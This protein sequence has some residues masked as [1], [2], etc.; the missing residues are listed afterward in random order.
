MSLILITNPPTELVASTDWTDLEAR[1]N[2]NMLGY[3]LSIPTFT[4]TNWDGSTTIPAIAQGSIV[5]VG[6]SF[7]QADVD[8]ALTLE[9]GISDGIVH[10][11][12][13]TTDAGAT[14]TPTLTSD[15]IPV[16]DATKS[17]WYTGVVKYLPF[18]MTKASASYTNKGEYT[19]QNK[20]LT[21]TELPIGFTYTQY[22][23]KKSPK[24]LGFVGTWDN[25][26][27]EFAGDFFRAEGGNASAFES[28]QQ[29][30]KVRNHVHDT[31]I[32]SHGHDGSNIPGGGAPGAIEVLDSAL[33]T[34]N[35]AGGKD[36][37]IR[38][39]SLG[40][41]TSG[42]PTANANDDNR[43]ENRTVIIWERTA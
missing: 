28:G 42:N 39:T 3:G 22:P 27:S 23:N 9:G 13:D 38:Q 8:T 10:I 33:I 11:K 20:G 19:Q 5:E 43:P 35:L 36:I 32:G 25:I 30:S 12:L 26:S 31:V 37:G 1:S 17:G 40:T 41:K 4:L 6:G 15:S 16:W 21:G 18:E 14:M 29:T 7:Y 2:A 24:E 34:G